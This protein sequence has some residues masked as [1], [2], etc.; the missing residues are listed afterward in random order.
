VAER[1]GGRSELE[2]GEDAELLDASPHEILWWSFGLGLG[3]R[4]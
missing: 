3:F 1:G 4:V 2:G